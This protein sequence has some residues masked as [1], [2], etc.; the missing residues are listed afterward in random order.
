MVAVNSRYG[1]G[2]IFRGR[3]HVDFEDSKIGHP[4]RMGL[5]NSHNVTFWLLRFYVVRRG[6]ERAS[7]DL[8][9]RWNCLFKCHLADVD[10]VN[11]IHHSQHGSRNYTA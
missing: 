1:N 3:L 9:R 2:R 5:R 8:H 7:H 4:R 10:L 11:R 6:N